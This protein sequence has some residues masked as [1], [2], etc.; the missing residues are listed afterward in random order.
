ME[1]ELELFDSLDF[2][3]ERERSTVQVHNRHDLNTTLRVELL[4]SD[5]PFPPVPLTH[6]VI[7]ESTAAGSWEPLPDPHT[8]PV[9]AGETVLL[10]LAPARAAPSRASTSKLPCFRVAAAL[11]SQPWHRRTSRTGSLLRP[12][13]GRPPSSGRSRRRQRPA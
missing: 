7:D 1:V 10:T 13:V 5:D 12:R 11:I 8:L 4:D 6:E 2:G 3:A 9:P